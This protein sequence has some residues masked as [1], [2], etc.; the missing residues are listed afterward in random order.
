M[1]D[2]TVPPTLP[3][4]APPAAGSTDVLA[5]LRAAL[6]AAHAVALEEAHLQGR[7]DQAL[8]DLSAQ[9]LMQ[10]VLA[11]LRDGLDAVLPVATGPEAAAALA[12]LPEPARTVA[13]DAVKGLQALRGVLGA[14]SP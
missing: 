2:P 4:P 10:A 6:P 13:A 14:F 12:L 3:P 7:L 8:V 9:P 11:D 1:T 5:L